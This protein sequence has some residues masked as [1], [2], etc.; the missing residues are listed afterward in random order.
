MLGAAAALLYV[1]FILNSGPPIHWPH[2]R[3]RT[4]MGLYVLTPLLIFAGAVWLFSW[5]AAHIDPPQ[6]PG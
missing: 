4:L 2:T 5:I 3:A 6:P 1:A